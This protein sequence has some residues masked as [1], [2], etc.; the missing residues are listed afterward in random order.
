MTT[1][2]N[3][4][5]VNISKRSVEIKFKLIFI[6]I[7]L[8]EMHGLERVKVNATSIKTHPHEYTII[9]HWYPS[10]LCKSMGWFLYDRNLRHERVNFSFINLFSCVFRRYKMGVLAR[11]GLI[12]VFLIIQNLWKLAQFC[13]RILT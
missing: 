2:K 8:S 7:Q 12:F 9:Y 13:N 5:F 4:F 3:N 10:L 11:N 6:W 1:V